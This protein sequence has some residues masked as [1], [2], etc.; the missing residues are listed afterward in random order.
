MGKGFKACSAYQMSL[1]DKKQFEEFSREYKYYIWIPESIATIG[2]T[3]FFYDDATEFQGGIGWDS[4]YRYIKSNPK[5]VKETIKTYTYTEEGKDILE[6]LSNI[7]P[8]YGM[9]IYKCQHCEELYGSQPEFALYND[10][11]TCGI[12]QNMLKIENRDSH[13]LENC[14]EEEEE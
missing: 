6:L 13:G 7:I 9:E 2:D 12:C 14:I 5:Q 8:T 1:E 11:P 10:K 3:Y 4:I